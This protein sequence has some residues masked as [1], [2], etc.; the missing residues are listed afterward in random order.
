MPMIKLDKET[1][2]LMEKAYARMRP[3]YTAPS[4]EKI[5]YV[6][7]ALLEQWD[8]TEEILA[9][10]DEAPSAVLSSDV[11]LA[12]RSITEPDIGL[13]V[14]VRYDRTTPRSTDGLIPWEY[15]IEGYSKLPFV[16]PLLKD[17][18]EHGERHVLLIRTLLTRIPEDQWESEQT[19]SIA[20][21]A[22]AQVA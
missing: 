2:S 11:E 5:V 17:Y 19:R 8:T 9:E 4:K 7:K 16:N 21:K 1:F 13:E 18:T 15:I 22:L 20:V 3:N 6:L 10:P 14:K 12:L